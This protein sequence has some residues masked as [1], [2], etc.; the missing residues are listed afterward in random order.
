MK[1]SVKKGALIKGGEVDY[2]KVASI[3][4]NDIRNNNIRNI[5]FDRIK[6]YE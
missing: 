3:V 6:D 2:D 1:K 4:I 5:T